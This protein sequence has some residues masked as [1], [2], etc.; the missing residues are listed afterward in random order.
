MTLEIQLRRTAEEGTVPNP[1]SLLETRTLRT[2]KAP[3]FSHRHAHYNLQLQRNRRPPQP[4]PPAHP[5][6]PI[7]GN[8]HRRNIA[9]IKGYF[10]GKILARHAAKALAEISGSLRC[11]SSVQASRHEGC[12]GEAPVIPYMRSVRSKILDPATVT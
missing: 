5:E 11:V 6:V 3:P 12:K 10:Q 7:E 1:R 8:S 9:G 2:A 4:R